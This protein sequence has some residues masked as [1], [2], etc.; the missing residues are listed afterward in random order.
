MATLAQAL[1]KWKADTPQGT[2]LL[3]EYNALA[4]SMAPPLL[5]EMNRQEAEAAKRQL[6]TD[7]VNG[8]AQLQSDLDAVNAAI[9]AVPPTAL[10]A[11]QIRVGFRDCLKA[12]LWIS[13]RIAD[14]TIVIKL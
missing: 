1:A 4:D 2:M 10:S 12:L 14:G 5:E 13:D 9:N 8:R 6:I 11:A 7:F 3:A